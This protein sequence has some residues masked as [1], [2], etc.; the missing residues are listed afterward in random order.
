MELCQLL[1]RPRCQNDEEGLVLGWESLEE[2]DDACRR[3]SD[4][5][6]KVTVAVEE[7]LEKE[8]G[9]KEEQKEKEGAE[10]MEERFQ[11]KK[12][13]YKNSGRNIQRKKQY[14]RSKI[15]RK[16]C[17]AGKHHSVAFHSLGS[18]A[19]IPDARQ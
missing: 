9:E 11:R 6:F 10:R 7:S 12:W 4:P 13:K 15:K 1:L 14:P 17:V 3:G 5:A 19:T 8:E 16:R 2:C 18:G